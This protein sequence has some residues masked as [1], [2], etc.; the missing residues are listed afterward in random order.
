MNKALVGSF[1]RVFAAAAFAAYLQTG[2]APLDLGWADAKAFL[3]A[4]I[5]A[6]VLTCYNYLRPGETRFGTGQ[7]TE[8]ALPGPGED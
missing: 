6:L 5:A 1:L 7:Q 2:K 3:N 4:G 8:V